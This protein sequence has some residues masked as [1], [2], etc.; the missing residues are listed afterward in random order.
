MNADLRAVRERAKMDRG[1]A[2]LTRNAASEQITPMEG[3]M[4]KDLVYSIPA[5]PDNT[6]SRYANELML[7]AVSRG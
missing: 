1:Y 6:P 2:S 7:R 5:V 3:A 4:P